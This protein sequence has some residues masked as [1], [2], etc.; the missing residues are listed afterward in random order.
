MIRHIRQCFF[1]PQFLNSCNK[2]VSSPIIQELYLYTLY[3]SLFVSF[4]PQTQE[5]D[6][7]DIIGEFIF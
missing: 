3:Y 4:F 6:D 7:D 2:I 1:I 5:N